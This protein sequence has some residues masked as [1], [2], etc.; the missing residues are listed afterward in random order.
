MASRISSGGD[1]LIRIARSGVVNIYDNL[2]ADKTLWSS[3]NLTFTNTSIISLP[4]N[5]TYGVIDLDLYNIEYEIEINWDRPTGTLPSAHLAMGLNT[6]NTDTNI[7]SSNT[8]WLF[9]L[10]HATVQNVAG[11]S[12]GSNGY[13]QH[14]NN[15]FY[16]GYSAGIASTE[17]NVRCRTLLTGKLNMQKRRVA[18]TSNLGGIYTSDWSFPART[19]TNV[20]NSDQ[21]SLLAENT[22][23]PGQERSRLYTQTNFDDGHHNIHGT[24]I[25]ELTSS[26]FWNNNFS[27]GISSIQIASVNNPDFA[28]LSRTSNVSAR[29]WRVKK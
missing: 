2:T 26:N 28:G 7:H 27:G 23:T 3:S 5:A 9:M 6:I 17:I 1:G 4:I 14:Y 15:R 18:Q 20:F 29:F 12:Q 22:G 24:A 16:C 19:L 21:Y 10:E 8:S 11:A 13:H 25:W